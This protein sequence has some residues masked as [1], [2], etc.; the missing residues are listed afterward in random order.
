MKTG[1]ATAEEPA[2]PHSRILLNTENIAAARKG[3][4]ILD[5]VSLRVNAGEVVG[6]LGPNG[7]GKT[8]F[9]SIIAGKL[10]A[11]N[12]KIWIEDQEVTKL[13]PRSRKQFG[14]SVC[15]SKQGRF[16]KTK[17]LLEELAVAISQKPKVVCLDEPFNGVP[18]TSLTYSSILS[19]IETLKK[20]GCGVLVTE[21][22]VRETLNIVDR[23]YLLY[24]GRILREGTS[25]FLKGSGSQ[26]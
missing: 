24:D 2:K 22:N 4:K 3:K 12:G 21:H 13:T 10:T 25:I 14:L 8:S 6:L 17:S 16:F 23:A 9:L 26:Q 11:D 7:A 15:F 18:T 20:N 19:L 5:Q 1:I